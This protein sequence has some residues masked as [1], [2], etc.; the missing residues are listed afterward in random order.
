MT[1]D[2]LNDEFNKL[3]KALAPFQIFQAGFTA[4][5]VSMRERAMNACDG[6][7]DSNAIKNA[8]GQLPDIKAGVYN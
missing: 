5:A 6:K 1:T 2:Y 4:G 8:I 7:T 3:D